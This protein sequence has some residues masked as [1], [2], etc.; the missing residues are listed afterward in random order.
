[1]NKLWFVIISVLVYKLLIKSI[2][3]WNNGFL[4]VLVVAFFIWLM[5]RLYHKIVAPSAKP[6]PVEVPKGVIEKGG[7]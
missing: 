4:A 6:V 1:M 3:G 5:F 7:S 2:C